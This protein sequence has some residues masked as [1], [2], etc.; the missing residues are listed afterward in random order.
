MALLDDILK[1]ATSSLTA[2]QRDALRRLFQKGVLDQQDF[3][4]LYAM[5]KSAYGV[6]DSENREPDPLSQKH[7]PVQTVNAAPVTLRAMRELKHVNRIPNGQI[8]EFSPKG[9]TVI[10][11][12]NAAGKS[13][14]SRVLKQACRARDSL[15]TVHLD[16]RFK[17]CQWI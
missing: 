6:P 11:G 9:M 4:D 13:G 10:Y 16:E 12:G 3:D 15:E 2:W 8:L 5:L 17:A 14:Y 7:L 1:W